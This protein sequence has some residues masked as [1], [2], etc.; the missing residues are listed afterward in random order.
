MEVNTKIKVFNF[1]PYECEAAEEYLN[2]MARSGWI[3]KSMKGP[4][5]IFKR[6]KSNT[7]RYTVDILHKVSEYDCKDSNEVLEY[8]DYCE[9]A[10]WKF[11][12]QKG[13]VQIFYTEDSQNTL[14][15]HT[16]EKV[17]FKSVFKASLYNALGQVALIGMWLFFIYMQLFASST[18][19]T[20]SSNLNVLT[21]VIFISLI[22]IFSIEVVSFVIWA[23][24]T[25]H[26]LKISKSMKYN[27][28]RQI[29][30]KRSLPLACVLIMF[31]GM[32]Y[33]TSEI[34]VI[35]MLIMISIP[36]IV[37][38]II[39]LFINKKRYSKKVNIA[40]TVL[41]L[42]ISTFFVMTVIG[43]AIG[44]T[45]I[46]RHIN[47]SDNITELSLSDFGYKEAANLNP[48]TSFNESIL[49]KK[50]V[51]FSDDKEQDLSYTIFESKYPM[52]VN[53]NADRLVKMLNKIK[54][55]VREY[56]SKLPNDVKVYEYN[57]SKCFILVSKNKMIDTRNNFKDMDDDKFLNIVYDKLFKE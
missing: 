39:R 31:V 47:K 52:I 11:V 37:A 7:V 28:Y 51:Y 27:N 29:R 56:K 38:L 12:G 30:I 49:A 33:D 22:I 8:R 24:K 10:G 16:D 36:I 35:T 32:I 4:I 3:L 17:K 54:F 1:F 19:Y 23:V 46:N 55:N 25:N 26:N 50:S 40:I 20:L 44:R 41:G 21:I 42:L 34:S 18:D 48:Y 15:I 6:Y 2:D 5:L 14:E 13:T 53:F 43:G 9:A 45:I 57:E